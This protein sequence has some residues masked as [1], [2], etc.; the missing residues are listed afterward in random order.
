MVAVLMA[1]A[2]ASAAAGCNASSSTPEDSYAIAIEQ[3][4]T[5]IPG[6]VGGAAEGRVVD[7]LFT[8]LVRYDPTTSEPIL[9]VA[10]SIRSD[11][12]RHWTITIERGWTFHNGEPVTADNFVRAWNATAYAPNQWAGSRLLRRVEGYDAV[13]PSDPDGANGPQ[14][15][16]KP[17]AK[18]L[19]GLSVVGDY[20]FTVTLREPFSQFPL[21]LGQPALSPLPSVA[22]Q[23]FEKFGRQPIGNGP[24][25]M[26]GSWPGD[27]DIR[28]T[29]YDDYTKGDEHTE[30]P[31]DAADD[32]DEEDVEY[33]GGTFEA[34]VRDLVYK[35]YPDVD[36]A[37]QALADGEV[38][39]VPSLP[40]RLFDEAQNDFGDRFVFRP[41]TTLVSLSVP[42]GDKRLDQPLLRRALSMAIDRDALI[43]TYL[44]DVPT[45]AESLVS[46]AVP[47]SRED[48]C[49]DW[50]EFHPHRAKELLDAAGGYDG[51]LHLWLRPGVGNRQLTQ[52]IGEMLRRN[53]GIDEV[54]IHQWDPAQ[55][56]APPGN[57]ATTG[58]WW[59]AWAASYPSP[60]AYLE[61]RFTSG[62]D[63][64]GTNYVSDRVDTLV[65]Q[66]NRATSL[67]A[68]V[69][70]YQHAEDIVL[71]DMP[72][73]P[74]WFHN[75][76][77]AHSSSVQSVIVD[78]TGH[79]QV[80]RVEEP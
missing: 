77:A 46:P 74:L 7:A 48:P 71:G 15:P 73:I 36:K 76:N 57:G 25:Q 70:Y 40:P 56:A 13:H 21:M 69:E 16:P 26:T 44:A 68:S 45:R 67:D 60:Q 35:T 53:L 38:D 65:R 24:Y 28:L 18:K 61:P 31:E 3:P 9:A 1:T 11:D 30:E 27:G 62:G 29:R 51:T 33:R 19:S 50:C 80:A 4:T 12:Q 75:T 8:G 64:G 17:E 10:K 34:S 49:A 37:Y 22:F 39:I 14:D 47:A 20:T 72:V 6:A 55:S 59:S 79:I 23:N 32:E 42:V 5:L 66:G 41:G 52:A 58:P 43:E 54:R 2:L 63:A 78:A